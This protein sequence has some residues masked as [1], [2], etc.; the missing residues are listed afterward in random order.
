MFINTPALDVTKRNY[1]IISR[2]LAYV[3]PA[4]MGFALDAWSYLNY[5]LVNIRINSHCS[6]CIM[7]KAPQNKDVFAYA[8]IITKK[9]MNLVF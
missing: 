6:P 2:E 7:L 1:S 3:N 5:L 9:H 4:E 8:I